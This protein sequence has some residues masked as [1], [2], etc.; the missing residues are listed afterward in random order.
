MVSYFDS[1]RTFPLRCLSMETLLPERKGNMFQRCLLVKKW[2]KMAGWST[3]VTHVVQ[4]PK[5]AFSVF[6]CLVVKC[7]QSQNVSVWQ[8][9][10]RFRQRLCPQRRDGY[11]NVYPDLL[12]W[13]C[14]PYPCQALPGL[15]DYTSSWRPVYSDSSSAHWRE[16]FF[17]SISLFAL[18]LFFSLSHDLL[19]F[20]G[21]SWP[22]LPNW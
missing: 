14:S 5:A 15:C 8:L 1:Y 3:Q 10:S 4:T 17:L 20:R 6:Y 21:Q 13:G 19:V 2:R 12:G 22:W 16:P 9:K 7:F 18:S 11:H